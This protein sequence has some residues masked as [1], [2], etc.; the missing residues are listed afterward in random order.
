MLLSIY[1]SAFIKTELI[2]QFM[3]CTYITALLNIATF[4]FKSFQNQSQNSQ[5]EQTL[6]SKGVYDYLINDV[7]IG[8]IQEQL[9][10]ILHK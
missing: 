9:W 2:A 4:S 10:L 3:N 8:T 1:G 5:R 7:E 6:N